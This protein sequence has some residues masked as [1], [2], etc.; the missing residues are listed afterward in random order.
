MVKALLKSSLGQT[1]LVNLKGYHLKKYLGKSGQEHAIDVSFETTLSDLRLLILVECK[2]Y[3][4]SVGV[5]DVLTFAYRL[6]D[7]GAHKGIIVTTQGFQ[8]GAVQVARAEGI[9]LLLAKR[10]VLSSYLGSCY[11]KYTLWISRIGIPI[12]A[13]TAQ[14]S[15][16]GI[17]AVYGNVFASVESLRD[18]TDLNHDEEI[19]FLLPEEHGAMHSQTPDRF[20]QNG[21]TPSPNSVRVA[22]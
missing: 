12:E 19:A 16:L 5:E 10:G 17:R 9:A 14:P 22:L 2:H 11:T 4:R 15:V 8:E 18:D 7:V 6:R 1:G 21:F 3:A 20:S 13:S